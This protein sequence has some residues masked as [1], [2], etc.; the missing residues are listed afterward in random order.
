MAVLLVGM[1][2]VGIILVRHENDS[3][4]FAL[5]GSRYAHHDPDGTQGYDGQLAYL[6]ARDP[7]NGWKHCDVP[8]YRYQCIHGF[9]SLATLALLLNESQLPI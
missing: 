5:V 2:Y 6:I 8:T 3:L 9:A 4:A 7:L 1:A